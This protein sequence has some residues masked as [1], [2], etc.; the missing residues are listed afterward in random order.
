MS[1]RSS[2]PRSSLMMPSPSVLL[3]SN[4]TWH[5]IA[6]T[7]T[8]RYMSWFNYIRAGDRWKKVGKSLGNVHCD[9]SNIQFM[10]HRCEAS[11]WAGAS[12]SYHSWGRGLSTCWFQCHFK[13][14]D[15]CF[16]C[17]NWIFLRE[18][19]GKRGLGFQQDLA[20]FDVIP[21]ST[22]NFG[23][24]AETQEVNKM[25]KNDE[26]WKV[27]LWYAMK[28]AALSFFLAVGMVCWTRHIFTPF[29]LPRNGQATCCS[30]IVDASPSTS[31]GSQGDIPFLLSLVRDDEEACR[32]GRCK[33]L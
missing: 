15:L 11:V 16:A 6:I 3:P 12:G 20:D 2:L 8:P 19:K 28:F 29:H 9:C 22:A 5:E 21:F 7:D 30:P 10:L 33:S 25:R 13:M 17:W 14:L 1:T 24:G 4:S 32:V 23:L 27:L 26:K 31:R 18:L